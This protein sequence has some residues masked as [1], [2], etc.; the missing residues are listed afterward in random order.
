M[1]DIAAALDADL[2]PRRARHDHAHQPAR[3]TRSGRAV[4]LVQDDGWRLPPA[5][6][7]TLIAAARDR[8]HAGGPSCATA[9]ID[10]TRLAA[11][12]QVTAS[13]MTRMVRLA[14]LSPAV[15]EAML[16]GR[17]RAG[18]DQKM[19]TLTTP[20]DPCWSKQAAAL[21]PHAG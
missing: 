20:P 8:T 3:L 16:A 17:Q 6:D 5:P 14:F 11:R 12:E 10:I 7:P 13:Y 1:P 18:V 2:P 21:L 15:T 9:T 19:L 4:R